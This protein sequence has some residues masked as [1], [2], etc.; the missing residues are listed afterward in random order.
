VFKRHLNTHHDLGFLSSLYSVALHKLTADKEHLLVGLRA[1]EVLS[2]RFNEKAHFI[3]AWGHLNTNEHDNAAIV[4]CLMNLPLLFW[5]SNESG[6]AKFREIAIKHADMALK[7]FIRPDGSVNHAY[8]FNLENGQPL[9]P[10]NFCGFS[11]ESHWARGAT[12]AVYGYA[13]SYTYTHEQRYLDASLKVA[14]KF[15]NLLDEEVVPVWDFSLPAEATRERDASAAAIM[16]CGLQELDKHKAAD[17][18]MLKA[19]SSLLD[20]I[21]SD[22]Y[23]DS[24]PECRGVLKKGQTGNGLG[25][26][27]H[28]YTSWGDYFLMEALSREL[29]ASP[30]FW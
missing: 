10:D 28:S 30:T 17:P 4:D 7:H 21:C 2:Q 12:W 8:R 11:T 1:A 5:A 27:R 29:G 14:R 13:L 20:R 24:N 22:D 18:T 26:A 25:K 6:N 15:I 23:L 3:R 19:K 16:V 9:G